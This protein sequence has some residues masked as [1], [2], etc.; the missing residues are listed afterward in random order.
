MN[1][2]N[3]LK[4]EQLTHQDTGSGP[5]II[6]IHGLASDHNIWAGIIPFLQED[7]RVIAVDLRG[8]GSS[9][10][11]S[12]PYSME[13]FSRD[14]CSLL[15]SL[16]IRQ[17]HF[18][19][20]SMGGAVAQEIA[21]NN[22]D[23]VI[24]LTLISSFAYQD[25]QLK[26]SLINLR[27]VIGESGY[28]EFFNEC[29]KTTH[30]PGYIKE[31]LELL[32]QFRKD[33][34]KTSSIPSLIASINACLKVNNLDSLRNITAPTLIMSSRKD[35]FISTDQGIIMNEHIPHS[36]L[37]IIVGTSHNTIVEEPQKAYEVI[38]AFLDEF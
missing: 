24:S 32:N 18:I 9:S 2:M 5:P 16:N 17:A 38:K 35:R 29:L 30:S 20:H 28:D 21:I 19:G 12:G 14:I 27:N 23:R 8:H 6:L 10:K 31:N 25:F 3:A 15:D 34:S 13:L 11:T 33:M 7:Y 4:T 22:P 26:K 36:K 37:E 1:S